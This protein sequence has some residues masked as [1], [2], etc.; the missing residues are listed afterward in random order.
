M[1]GHFQAFISQCLRKNYIR[2]CLCIKHLKKN[3]SKGHFQEAKR[4][5]NNVHQ[6]VNIENYKFTHPL[7]R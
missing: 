6:I 2:K 3:N 4:G 1:K 7:A 5:G